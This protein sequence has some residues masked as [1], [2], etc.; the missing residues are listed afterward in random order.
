MEF[1]CCQMTHIHKFPQ[2]IIFDTL[3]AKVNLVEAP[4]KLNCTICAKS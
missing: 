1:I 3:L 2:L 4:Y